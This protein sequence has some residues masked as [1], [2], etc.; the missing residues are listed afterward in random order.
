M[1]VAPVMVHT[2]FVELVKET[3]NFESDVATNLVAIAAFVSEGALNV[4][5]C[6]PLVITNVSVAFG[7]AK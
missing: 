2:F 4:I 7:A 6:V 3:G 1:N 5:V